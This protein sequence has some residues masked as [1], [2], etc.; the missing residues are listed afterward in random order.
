MTKKKTLLVDADILIHQQALA[1]EEVICWD[2]E[3]DL[4]TVTA[5]ARKAKQKVDCEVRHYLD[6]LEADKAV[7]CFTAPNN[8]R[9]DVA[10]YYKSNRKKTRKPTIFPELR[11][12]CL[13]AYQCRVIDRLEADD[14]MGILATSRSIKGTKVIVSDDKDLLQIPGYVY[15]PSDGEVRKIT[16]KDADRWFLTQVLCGDATD[17]YPGLPGCG[18]KT[19]EKILEVGCW[20]EVVQ[21]YEKKG[22]GELEALTQARMARILRSTEYN[23]RSKKLKLWS[24]K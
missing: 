5:D 6:K 9:L 22:L 18:P 17:G 7:L 10:P 12:Y 8:F 2:Q 24:P 1:C 11:K 21:A 13:E 4:W 16:R 20:D 19:A 14:V 23:L 3:Q 15:R